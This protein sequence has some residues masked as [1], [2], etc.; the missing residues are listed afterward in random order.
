MAK[1]YDKSQSLLDVALA[2]Q[3]KRKSAAASADEIELSLAWLEGDVNLT[4]VSAALYPTEKTS[5]KCLY[6]I[7]VA[8]RAAFESGRLQ[9]K[10][11]GRA[12]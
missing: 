4:Q 1:S 2:R 5:G 7:A 10:T 6:R 11:K 12:A 9:V 3:P 8:L